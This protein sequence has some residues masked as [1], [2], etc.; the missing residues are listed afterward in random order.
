MMDAIHI[1]IGAGSVK[2]PG[3]SVG[4]GGTGA[5]GIHV[6]SKTFNRAVER[7]GFSSPA[8][9]AQV[10][11][12]RFRVNLTIAERPDLNGVYYVGG[13]L[14]EGL[15]SLVWDD[16]SQ[17]YLVPRRREAVLATKAKLSL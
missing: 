4:F 15:V 7:Q 2:E 6:D 14:D 3:K 12:S 1:S 10:T 5:W 13:W 11:E 8:G 16:L 17:G 9:A